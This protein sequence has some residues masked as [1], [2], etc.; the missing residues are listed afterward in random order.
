MVKMSDILSK[1]EEGSNTEYSTSNVKG[2]LS[3][4]SKTVSKYNSMREF[5]PENLK[6]LI[7][8]LLIKASYVGEEL[9]LLDSSGNVSKYKKMSKEIKDIAF[10]IK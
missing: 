7:Y 3:E 9:R 1:L 10:E 2:I 4:V 8:D 6:R 5:N